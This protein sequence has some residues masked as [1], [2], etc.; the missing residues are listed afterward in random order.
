MP[1]L[2]SCQCWVPSGLI[3][4]PLG[5]LKGKLKSKID[6]WQLLNA[7]QPGYE[8]SEVP[9]YRCTQRAPLPIPK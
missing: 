2:K 6:R 9:D 1:E 8:R 4:I 3:S 7:G 5:K